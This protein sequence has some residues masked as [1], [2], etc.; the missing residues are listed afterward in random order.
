MSGVHGSI[1]A[2][3]LTLA[4]A[5]APAAPREPLD[6]LVDGV[7]RLQG[8]GHTDVKS[9]RV[10]VILPE[11]PGGEVIPLVEEWHAPADLVVRAAEPRTPK[12]M[13]RSL[14]IY[15]EPLY[16][17]QASLLGADLESGR[18]SMR[19][20]C[21]VEAEGRRGGGKQVSVIFPQTADPQLPEELAD[22]ARVDAELDAH[23][24]LIALSV[25][26]REA[27]SL[28]FR[29]EY[30]GPEVPQPRR[31][32]WTLGRGDSVEVSTT[33]REVG[34]RWLPDTRR[35]VFPSRYA[36]GEREELFVRYGEW[37]LGVAPRGDGTAPSFRY[38]SRGVVMN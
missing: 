16:V 5:A 34:G 6:D 24:R 1:A 15:L 20:T 33:F 8:L 2:L 29:C 12:A 35:I 25:R 18:K 10:P 9:Y 17:A 27:D 30:A 19:S 22:L 4:A 3:A 11:D 26:T 21:R 32:S 23:G 13:V 7:L 36:P 28:S 31:A 38:D 37:E 14:A